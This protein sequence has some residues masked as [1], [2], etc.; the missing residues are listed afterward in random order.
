MSARVILVVSAND[1]NRRTGHNAAATTLGALLFLVL[2]TLHTG[3]SKRAELPPE[4]VADQRLVRLEGEPVF[5]HA[6]TRLRV[7]VAEFGMGAANSEPLAFSPDHLERFSEHAAVAE[8]DL[9]VLFDTPF[10]GNY[11]GEHNVPEEIA[12]AID[13]YNR[14]LLRSVIPR[15][16]DGAP[17]RE[18]SG[19]ALLLSEYPLSGQSWEELTARPLAPFYFPPTD[20]VVRVGLHDA[21]QDVRVRDGAGPIDAPDE[22]Q[23]TRS[24]TCSGELSAPGLFPI[25]VVPPS[26]WVALR[27]EAVDDFAGLGLRALKIEFELQQEPES[28]PVAP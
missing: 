21:E 22:L 13:R 1:H 18:V 27:S 11:V 6:P 20:S 16:Q 10:G 3:C 15:R 8:P 25:C 14:T 26:G 9:I 19:G 17:L 24:G 5:Q 2:C 28:V 12:I 23:I 4:G 7:L